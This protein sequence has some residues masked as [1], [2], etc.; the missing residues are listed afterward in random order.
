MQLQNYDQRP[1]EQSPP[2]ACKG[3]AGSNACFNFARKSQVVTPPATNVSVTLSGLTNWSAA[4]G[5]QIVG[6][7]WQ[8]TSSGSNTCSPN[9]TF[10]NVRFQ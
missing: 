6:V 7:Q 9:V 3:D 8:F 10:T 2:G 4:A 5:A 1:A